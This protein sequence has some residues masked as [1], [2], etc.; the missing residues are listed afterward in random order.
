MNHGTPTD[1]PKMIDMRIG[2][3]FETTHWHLLTV[4]AGEPGLFKGQRQWL[5]LLQ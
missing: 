5:K 2:I 1:V 3:C 4:V